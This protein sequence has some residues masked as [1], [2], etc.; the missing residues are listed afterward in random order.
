MTS[1]VNLNKTKLVSAFHTTCVDV[2]L[3]CRTS[4][5]CMCVCTRVTMGGIQL[6]FDYNRAMTPPIR[7]VF[8]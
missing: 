1:I 5:T 2:R 4:H 7:L 6:A 8:A 3:Y